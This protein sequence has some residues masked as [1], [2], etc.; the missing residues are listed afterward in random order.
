M[1]E[2]VIIDSIEG[3]IYGKIGSVSGNVAKAIPSP[4]RCCAI[5]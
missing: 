1:A 2:S 5:S 3:G 4:V